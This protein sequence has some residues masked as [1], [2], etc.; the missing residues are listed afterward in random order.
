MGLVQAEMRTSELVGRE[1]NVVCVWQ[2]PFQGGQAAAQAVPAQVLM[3]RRQATGTAG[4][5][6][7]TE[8]KTGTKSA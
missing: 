3:G 4:G 2:R 8:A 5:A 6:Q 7:R 1:V